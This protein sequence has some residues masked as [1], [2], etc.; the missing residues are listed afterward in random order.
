MHQQMFF[1]SISSVTGYQPAGALWFDNPDYL[2]RTPGSAGNRKT[3]TTS[4]WVKRDVL[5]GSDMIFGAGTSGVSYLNFDSGNTISVGGIDAGA[6][7]LV[8]TPVY[9]DP[10]AWYH[11]VRAVD[12]RAAVTAANRVRLYVNGVEVTAFGTRNNPGDDVEANTN[13]TVKHHIGIV[14]LTLSAKAPFYI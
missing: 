3:Y 5:G 8:T 6:T 2:T 11:I 13:N 9:R 12:T 4:F 1:G 7:A 14:I 10:T